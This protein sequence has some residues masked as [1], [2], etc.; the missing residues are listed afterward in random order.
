M[1]NTVLDLMNGCFER[2]PVLQPCRESVVSVFDMLVRCHQDRN[3]LL[4]CGNG[5][6]AADAEHITGELMNRFHKPRPL[7]DLMRQKLGSDET[8]IYLGEK[9]QQ[10][11]R[12]VSLVSQTALITA[13]A[14]DL[15]PDLV[16]AQQVYGYGRAGDLL[17]VLST[18]GNSGNVI[19]ALRVAKSLDMQTIGFTGES[20]GAMGPLCDCLIK[21]PSTHTPI[22]QEYHLIL[23]HLLCSM[24][25]AQ[26]F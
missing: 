24:I 3:M 16:F 15:G 4:V 10:A 12:A 17:W 23:Y 26:V 19:N 18:S 2:H 25:E 6:S 13:I 9:L 5:G 21:I 1:K 20:G 7:S 8:G 22:I 11:F 14:N